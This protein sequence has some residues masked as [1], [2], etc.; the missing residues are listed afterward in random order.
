M[1][2][3]SEKKIPHRCLLTWMFH[4]KSLKISLI[5]YLISPSKH[6]KHLIFVHILC[7]MKT[8]VCSVFWDVLMKSTENAFCNWKGNVCGKIEWNS[9]KMMKDDSP[10][11]KDWSFGWKNYSSSVAGGSQGCINAKNIPR[12]LQVVD[13]IPH[14]EKDYCYSQSP[15]VCDD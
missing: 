14:T 7:L 3:L 13:G 10:P 9:L 11:W 6:T 5:S 12:N 2:A 8:G 1:E 4:G 15:V